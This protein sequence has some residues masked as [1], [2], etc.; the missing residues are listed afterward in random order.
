M[1][2]EEA[3]NALKA[4]SLE[5][6]CV[7]MIL[8]QNA[9]DKPVVYEGKGYIRQGSDGALSFK[10]LVFKVQR[11]DMAN[12]L[13]GIRHGNTPCL[14]LHRRLQR[15]PNLE[16]LRRRDRPFCTV[17][18]SEPVLRDRNRKARKSRWQ[19][20]PLLV[21]RRCCVN[22]IQTGLAGIEVGDEAQSENDHA[23]DRV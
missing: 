15:N 9:S 19:K 20:N 18:C 10:I 17:S 13:M 6:D 12:D 8:T 22:M 11:T 3:I 23:H 16:T 4:N 14:P 2:I 5:I 1:N 21:A 7:E